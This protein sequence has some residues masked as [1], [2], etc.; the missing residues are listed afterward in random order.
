MINQ[1]VSPAGIASQPHIEEF[2]KTAAVKLPAAVSPRVLAVAAPVIAAGVFVFGLAVYEY[3]GAPR[4]AQ[5]LA[6]LFGLFLVMAL[7]ERFPV[8]VEGMG[9]NGVTLGFV[10][11]VSAIIL[12]G[13]PAGVIVAAGA[14]A[15]V[16]IFQ[17]RPPLRIAYNGSMFALSALAAGLAVE[18]VPGDSTEI[19]VARVVLC[20][21]VYCVV[22]LVLISAILAADSGRNFFTI[23][24]ENVVR[25]IAP[26]AFMV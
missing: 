14:P 18:H 25:T 8:Q 21:F 22:N 11:S 5:D 2:G 1:R 4:S 6:E 3:A 19:L 20:G 12:L 10:F 13:W 16:H 26:F 7:A 9:A 23:A 15:L 17:H 24:Q